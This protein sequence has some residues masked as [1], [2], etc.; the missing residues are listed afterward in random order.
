[1]S[2]TTWSCPHCGRK[3]EFDAQKIGAVE[4]CPDCKYPIKPGL[5]VK[6]GMQGILKSV[7]RGIRW[8]CLIVILFILFV[9]LSFGSCGHLE[10]GM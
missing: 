4:Q 1:M 10:N 2:T 8:A 6:A 7:G 5:P 3:V 9:A